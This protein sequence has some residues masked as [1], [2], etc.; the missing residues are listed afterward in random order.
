MARS[1]PLVACC[2]V[3]FFKQ[4][5]YLFRASVAPRPPCYVM[6]VTLRADTMGWGKLPLCVLLFPLRRDVRLVLFPRCVYVGLVAIASLWDLTMLQFGQCL[7]CLLN[8]QKYASSR[9]SYPP[10]S[11]TVVSFCARV[12]DHLGSSAVNRVHL[13]NIGPIIDTNLLHDLDL[14]FQGRYI[15]LICVI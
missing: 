10:S 11:G 13:S 2:G 15:Q 14:S 4:A 8:D 5:I 3:F 1:L 12:G 7:C 9:W 6:Q